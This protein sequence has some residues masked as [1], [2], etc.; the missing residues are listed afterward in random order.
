MEFEIRM[1]ENVYDEVHTLM[2][3]IKKLNGGKEIGGWLTG[4]WTVTPTKA[5]LILDKF[6]IPKQEVT[7]TEVD[8]SPESMLDVMNEIGIMESNRIRAHWHIH[9]FGNGDTN[10]SGIDDDKITNFMNPEKGREIFVFLLSSEDQMKARVE[11]NMK[12]TL[13]GYD[14]PLH[15]K[16]DDVKVHRGCATEENGALFQLLKSR[17]AEKVSEKKYEPLTTPYTGYE[18]SMWWKKETQATKLPQ[19]ELFKVH[20]KKKKILVRLHTPFY[21]Y[22]MNSDYIPEELRSS[23]EKYVAGEE[24]VLVMKSSEFTNLDEFAKYLQAHLEQTADEYYTLSMDLGMGMKEY[25]QPY[26]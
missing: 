15:R 20:K 1:K 24:T 19:Y 6:I 25:N 13:L 2:A 18:G 17:I 10:W 21:E 8:M 5:T 9:P 11:L 3:N 14:L 7:T 12:T 16:I 22:L 26:Y 23:K 4:D